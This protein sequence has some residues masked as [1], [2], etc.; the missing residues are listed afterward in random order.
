MNITQA[1]ELTPPERD[2]FARL[3]FE[4]DA[5]AAGDGG[6]AARSNGDLAY[7]LMKSLLARNAIPEPRLRFFNDPDYN[8]EGR[9]RSRREVFEKNGTRG[10]EIFR[11]GNFLKY[12]RY[13]L[14]GA[15][16]PPEVIAS[17]AGKVAD[18]GSITSGDIE[19]LE[20][21][22]RQQTREHRL[23]AEGAAEEFYKLALDLNL[24]QSYAASIR[25]SVRAVRFTGPGARPVP[26]R[27][28]RRAR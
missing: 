6:D 19:P 12:L 8:I 18:C 23:T 20:K 9:G 16:L 4:F 11:H 7:R 14:F 25:N 24:D 28:P 5:L 17:F 22:A 2:L 3:K 26:G 15:D 10:E 21:F 27:R 1:I 13:F